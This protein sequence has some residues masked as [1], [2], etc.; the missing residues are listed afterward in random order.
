MFP[1]CRMEGTPAVWARWIEPPPD[2]GKSAPLTEGGWK[3]ATK[4]LPAFE[5]ADVNG[6]TWRLT[7]LKGKV[8][9]INLWATWCG[10]CMAE[11]P[12][13]QK[14]FEATRDR[15]DIQ[16]LT[17]N[18][19]DDLGLVAPF[20]AEKK[21]TFPVLPAV[22][23][24]RK[25]LDDGLAIPQNWLLDATGKWRLTQIGFNVTETDWAGAVTKKLEALK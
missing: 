21:F 7:E 18:V 3:E 25:M 8:V 16:V 5:L 6:K 4:D 14:L 13:V 11:L 2:A 19:D 9:L 20:L 17:F 23:L 22:D 15:K 12:H 1:N 10:P 24:V